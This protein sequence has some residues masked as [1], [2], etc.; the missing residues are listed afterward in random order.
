L[1]LLKEKPQEKPALRGGATFTETF[2]PTPAARLLPAFA[3]SCFFYQP[4]KIH[5][6]AVYRSKTYSLT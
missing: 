2:S 5:S 6:A 4:L 1:K 3:A